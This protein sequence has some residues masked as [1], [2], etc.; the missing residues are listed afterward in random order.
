MITIY[1]CFNQTL[2]WLTIAVS[3]MI[4]VAQKNQVWE[5]ITLTHDIT[6]CLLKLPIR[7]FSDCREY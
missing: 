6:P 3:A 5:F 2:V 1:W 7:L 4:G